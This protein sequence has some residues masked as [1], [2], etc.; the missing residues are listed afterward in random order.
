LRLVAALSVIAVAAI[1]ATTALAATV[2][3]P[4]TIS[5]DPSTGAELTS[6]EGTWTPGS[7]TPTYGWLRCDA[8]G[9]NCVGISGACGRRYVVRTAD[10]GRTLRVRLSV[11]DGSTDAKDS[12]QTVVITRK[13]YSIPP[14]TEEDTC[15]KVTPTGPGQGT[16]TSGTQTPAGTT[17]PPDTALPFIDPFPIVR[18]A[19]RFKGRRTT[20]RR[21]TVRAPRG[22]RIRIACKGRGCPYK[23]RAIAVRF[24]SVRS[25]QRTYRPRATIE[26]RVTQPQKIG[27]YTRLRTR[28]GKA[29][30]RLDRCLMPG[31]TT[32]ERCPQD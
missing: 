29:P 27:K 5:G 20:L 2:T 17:P 13:P 22:A 8:L 32:P 18:I 28:R 6:T 15:T 26:I 12:P 19:G 16:F 24:I 7:A 23:R 11:T 31:E 14:T 30:L 1:V 4:P 25:L 21:V 9:E 3:S 10:E